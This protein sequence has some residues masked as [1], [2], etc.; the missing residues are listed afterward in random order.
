MTAPDAAAVSRPTPL[1]FDA[2]RACRQLAATDAVLG[3]LM[4]RVGPYAPHSTAAPDAFHALLRAIVYQQ[5]SGRAAATIHRRVL[6][7]L[8]QGHAPGP[9]VVAAADEKQL[10][11]AGLSANKVAGIQALARAVLDGSVPQ[12]HELSD[13]DDAALIARYTQIRGIGRWT[14]EM[15]LIFHLGRPDVM[16]CHDLGVRKGYALSYGLEA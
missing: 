11:A 5:L 4:E 9:A 7:T 2:V 15:L 14:A 10:R 8:G 12:E 6:Q 1:R 13:I 16:P 3:K